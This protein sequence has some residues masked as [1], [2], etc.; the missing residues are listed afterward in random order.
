MSADEDALKESDWE[1]IARMIDESGLTQKQM[2]EKGVKLSQGAI[3]AF[4]N[5]KIP[6][7]NRAITEINKAV[8]LDLD[9][10]NIS[11]KRRSSKRNNLDVNIDV[12]AQIFAVIDKIEDKEGRRPTLTSRARWF[13]KMLKSGIP[14]FD[15]DSVDDMKD[16]IEG[17]AN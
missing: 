11:E 14:A 6:L 9:R 3:S 15:S 13:T 1:Y 10:F 17:L 2:K 4:K 8:P 16:I 7:T 12:V 5:G